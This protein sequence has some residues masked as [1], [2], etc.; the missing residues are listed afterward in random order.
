M[1]EG[2]CI[3]NK[4]SHKKVSFSKKV[5]K[6]S[7]HHAVFRSVL[8][9]LFL[10]SW[11]EEIPL[12]RDLRSNVFPWT[13]G[14]PTGINSSPRQKFQPCHTFSER[15][16]K[17]PPFFGDPAD[18][19]KFQSLKMLKVGGTEVDH[20]SYI[21]E[22]K[23]QRFLFLTRN[24]YNWEV[25]LHRHGSNHILY[26]YMYIYIYIYINITI[27]QYIYIYIYVCVCLFP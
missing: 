9:Y 13:S 20:P 5:A 19:Q 17:I 1:L 27:Y 14:Y 22:G 24:D 11:G 8:H 25:R 26:V 6:E 4:K 7:N 2:D 21:R 16:R 23:M 3:S 18:P 10:R 12:F 15:S